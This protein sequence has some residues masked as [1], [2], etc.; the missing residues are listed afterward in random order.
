MMAFR[1]AETMLSPS[2]I[3]LSNDSCNKASQSEV[4]SDFCPSSIRGCLVPIEYVNLADGS[5]VVPRH[6]THI[7]HGHLHWFPA[8]IWKDSIN[9]AGALGHPQQIEEF[10]FS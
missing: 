6:R 3:K 2:M 10:I 7:L 9:S 5:L 4:S 1:A 8:Q